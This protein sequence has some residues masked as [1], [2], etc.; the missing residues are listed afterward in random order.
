MATIR[1]TRAEV[2]AQIARIATM[3]VG[4]YSWTIKVTEGE[5]SGYY[6]IRVSHYEHACTGGFKARMAPG[7][8][9]AASI[10][11]ELKCDVYSLSDR[12]K[13]SEKEYQGLVSF[14]ERTLDAVVKLNAQEKSNKIRFLLGLGESNHMRAFS[15]IRRL[16]VTMEEIMEHIHIGY[17]GSV[18]VNGSFT[19]SANY[20]SELE[21]SGQTITVEQLRE[22]FA[23]KLTRVSTLKEAK[24]EQDLQQIAQKRKYT[25]K[26]SAIDY[27]LENGGYREEEKPR[28]REFIEYYSANSKLGEFGSGMLGIYY[29]QAQNRADNRSNLGDLTNYLEYIEPAVAGKLELI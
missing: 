18:H 25:V 12:N 1:Y 3:T 19:L 11:K 24:F 8:S 29:N 27:H 23:H 5:V 14:V 17:G 10:R 28:I 7:T 20:S 16:G 4:G 26:Q 13:F 15:A 6:R 9:N 21:F 22:M 2:D